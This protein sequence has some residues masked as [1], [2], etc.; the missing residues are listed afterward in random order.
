MAQR[1]QFQRFPLLARLPRLRPYPPMDDEWPDD[2]VVVRPEQLSEYPALADDLRLWVE[3]FEPRFRRLDH[4]ARV[5]QN[6][7]WRQ[8]GALILGGLV[9]TV[10]G[11]V[12][13]A[14]GGG[15]EW[16]AAL[17]AVLTGVLAGVTVLARSRRAQD[18]YLNARLKAERMKSE[19][20]LFIARAGPYAGEARMAT[21]REQVEDIEA[22]EG[23]G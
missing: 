10:L 3:Q 4:R 18:G 17:Q 20:Y 5:L 23:L 16:L 6:Q 8:H 2:P 12:Q 22:A 13:A 21:L 19:F 11:A 14:R 1:G 15:V 9:A 7:F